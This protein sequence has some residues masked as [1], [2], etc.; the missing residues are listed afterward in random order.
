MVYHRG[1]LVYYLQCFKNSVDNKELV[2]PA[3]MDLS[4]AL[5][6]VIYDLLIEK[7]IGFGLKFNAL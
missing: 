5:N 2:G 7:F 1:C 6:C 4:K 3:V